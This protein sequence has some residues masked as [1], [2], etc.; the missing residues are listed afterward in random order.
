MVVLCP[1]LLGGWEFEDDDFGGAINQEHV[2]LWICGFVT[3]NKENPINMEKVFQIIDETLCK[4]C[5]ENKRN[6]CGAGIQRHQQ[7]DS[8]GLD[9]L[10][11]NHNDV[12]A[13]IVY[14]PC[15]TKK[16]R[17]KVKM[18]PSLRRD[19]SMMD[20]GLGSDIGICDFSSDDDDDDT[21]VLD[22]SDDT[23]LLENSSEEEEVKMV[24]HSKLRRLTCDTQEATDCSTCQE[25]ASGSPQT[26]LPEQ[27]E[28]CKSPG[29]SD[30]SCAQ[31]SNKHED[32]QSPSHSPHSKAAIT[33]AITPPESPQTSDQQGKKS[34]RVHCTWGQGMVHQLTE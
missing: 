25:Q 30:N 23:L 14:S 18:K 27:G 8:L 3:N 33:N 1:H 6:L 12:V 5:R 9:L 13:S 32:R 24:V 10:N 15:P 34:S 28:I 19:S 11:N 2:D 29:D 22:D 7:S 31:R 17:H 20:S 16:G 4:S 21:L 26:V